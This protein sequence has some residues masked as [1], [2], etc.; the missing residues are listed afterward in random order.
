MLK[1]L[2]VSRSALIA[3]RE[4]MNVIAGNIAFASTPVD[5]N[6]PASSFQRR[7]VEFY[8][9]QN[10]GVDTGHVGYRV[11]ADEVSGTITKPS[12]GDPRADENG[13]VHYPNINLMDEFADAVLASRAYEANVA[14]MQMTRQMAEQ[15]LRLLQ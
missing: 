12:P 9:D 13:N 3:Q 15:A 10:H 2:D 14:A 8:P 5:P 11:K 4:R 6:A 1:T 7:Y